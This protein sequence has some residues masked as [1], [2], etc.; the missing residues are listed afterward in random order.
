MPVPL[1]RDLDLAAPA[2]SC[3]WVSG[4][5]GVGKTTLLRI[6]SGLIKPDQGDVRIMGRSPERDRVAFAKSIGLLS[7]GNS[8][9][10]SRLT[11]REHLDLWGRLALMPANARVRAVERAVSEFE[12]TDI[13]D[14]RADRLSLG[15]RQRVRIALAFV[16]R[17][18][19]AMLDEPLTSLDEEGADLVRRVVGDFCAEGGAVVICSPSGDEPPMGLDSRLVLRDGTLWPL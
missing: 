11:A 1:L 2:G 4:R 17:P 3:T 8:A 7:A 9:L 5:N 14:R 16:H 13:S 12:L 10:Y 15:Q 6:A 18:L 19:V